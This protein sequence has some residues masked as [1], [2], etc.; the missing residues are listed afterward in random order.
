MSYTPPDGDKVNFS[1]NGMS[2]YTPPAGDE[3]NFTWVT[4]ARFKV[5]S[6]TAWLTGILKRWSGTDWIV[7]P[8]KYWTGTEWKE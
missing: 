6:G 1:W 4:G 5:W 8:F 2:P 7:Y 3:V